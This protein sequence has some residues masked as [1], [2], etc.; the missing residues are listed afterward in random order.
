MGVRV[1]PGRRLRVYALLARFLFPGHYLGKIFLLAFIATHVPLVVLVA[2]LLFV[3]HLP[4]A[5]TLAVALVALAATLVGT[6]LALL[7]LWVLLGP[8][9]IAARALR[10]YRLHGALPACR[11][12]LAAKGVSSWPTFST[13][14]P[15]STRSS[16]TWPTRPC[17]TR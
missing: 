7:G 8:V 14:W 12:T 13:P 5:S 1:E 16:A 3:A 6:A 2:Y 10:A 4:E 9:A 15:T 17:T 11:P